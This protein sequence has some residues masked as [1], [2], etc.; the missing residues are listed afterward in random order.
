M[1]M[2]QKNEKL[3]AAFAHARRLAGVKLVDWAAEHGLSPT[4]VMRSID[5]APGVA[6]E[7]QASVSDAI[8]RFVRKHLKRA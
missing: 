7:T 4:H 2:P 1:S 3:R 5:G 8:D 6:S